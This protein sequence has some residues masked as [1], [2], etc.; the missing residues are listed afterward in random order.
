LRQL[1]GEIVSKINNL[2]SNISILENEISENEKN[3]I[4]YEN[5]VI[6]VNV[7]L[8]ESL[9]GEFMNGWYAYTNLMFPYQAK[10]KSE[11]AKAI[12]TLWL[13]NRL[14]KLNSDK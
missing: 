11:E 4:G 6:P 10:Q 14:E 3:I 1:L 5:G 9:I 7:P 8:L 12:Q 13:N 2:K